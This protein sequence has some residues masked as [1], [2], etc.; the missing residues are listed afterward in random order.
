[1]FA[2]KIMLIC[3][4][5][6]TQPQYYKRFRQEKRPPAHAHV[7]ISQLRQKKSKPGRNKKSQSRGYKN[8]YGSHVIAKINFMKILSQVRPLKMILGT[9]K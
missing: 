3:F 7:E 5:N 6:I 1:M 8:G 4:F 9:R 2:P